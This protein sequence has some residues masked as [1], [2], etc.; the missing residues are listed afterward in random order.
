MSEHVNAL[1]K[2]LAGNERNVIIVAY[3]WETQMCG[4]NKRAASFYID[5]L[6]PIHETCLD[7]LSWHVC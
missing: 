1:V 3:V 6:S 2:N 5:Q 4:Y 7:G